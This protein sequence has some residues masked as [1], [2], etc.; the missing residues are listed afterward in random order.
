MQRATDKT[1]QYELIKSTYGGRL[2]PLIFSNH[3]PRDMLE[4]TNRGNR[5][6]QRAIEEL[7][8]EPPAPAPAPPPPS[9]N[10]DIYEHLNKDAIVNM[11]K[12]ILEG[13]KAHNRDLKKDAQMKEIYDTIKNIARHLHK[14]S[15]KEYNKNYK[16]NRELKDAVLLIL[17][18]R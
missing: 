11:C 18:S 2:M 15:E 3:I 7:I 10:D 5:E 14:T 17:N 8:W 12:I 4:A 16:N 9:A 13:I 1:H 6:E